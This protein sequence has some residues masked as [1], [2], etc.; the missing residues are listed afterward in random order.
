MSTPA[1]T[2]E[3]APPGAIIAGMARAHR[4]TQMIYAAAELGLADLLA[5]GPRAAAELAAA[6]GA[7]APSLRRLLR[8]LAAFG[9]VAEEEDG[10][11]ALT[12]EGERLRADVPGS[13]R[14]MVLDFGGLAYAT[15]AEF[16]HAVRT[17]GSAH[18]RVHGMTVWEYYAR[19]PEA[20]A[21]FDAFMAAA[22]ARRTAALLAA[23]D[24]GAFGTIVDIGGGNGAFL[25]ALL[26][27]H[28]GARGVLFDQ[29]H[30]VAAAEAVLA[31]AGAGDRCRVV[32]GDFFADAVAG[33]DAY[34]LK[35]I[36][37]DWDDERAAAILATCR[38][39]MPPGGRLL[40]ME[41]V[42]PERATVSPQHQE[43]FSLDL[44]M[45]AYFGGAQERTAEEFRALFAAAGFALTGIVPTA[46]PLSVIE[47]V[48]I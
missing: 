10:R 26:A 13:L 42:L 30:V 47:G 43:A 29:P 41:W 33:G 1:T 31:A 34:M 14:S 20:G 24:F 17:G 27:A 38:R 48:P 23:Y 11:F 3:A 28:P 35:Q 5:A 7:H 36:L 45:L 9:V 44:Q 46:S 18:E 12:A 40:V 2:P 6:T 39:A 16:P 19:H 22:T 37:H 32:G 4:E 8:A 21:N 15:W 25:A